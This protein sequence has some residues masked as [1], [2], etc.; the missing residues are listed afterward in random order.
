MLQLLVRLPWP[1][2]PLAGLREQHHIGRMLHPLPQPTLRPRANVTSETARLTASLGTFP[3]MLPAR[4]LHCAPGVKIR[5]AASA[6]HPW[7]VQPLTPCLPLLCPW[8]LL[9]LSDSFIA[10]PQGAFTTGQSVKALV[11]EVR[12]G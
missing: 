12:R 10:D 4:A 7:H 3:A 5:L 8:S 6:L 9:Q 1:R 11:V 2:G